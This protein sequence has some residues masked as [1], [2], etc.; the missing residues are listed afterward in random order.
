M[1]S[2][3]NTTVLLK[4]DTD[5]SAITIGLAAGI[6]VTLLPAFTTQIERGCRTAEFQSAPFVF[7]APWR[8]LAF[9]PAYGTATPK[10]RLFRI[11]DIVVN[12]V[13]RSHY[14]LPGHIVLVLFLLS[15]QFPVVNNRMDSVIIPQFLFQSAAV[16]PPVRA[17]VFASLRQP[18]VLGKQLLSCNPVPRPQRPK[19]WSR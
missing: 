10:L 1:G 7:T 4:R 13:Q 15:P 6:A 11:K 16:K 9:R 12:T 5:D 8:H 18:G 3:K 17:E 14:P 2:V 19:P